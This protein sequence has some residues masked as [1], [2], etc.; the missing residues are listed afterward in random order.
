MLGL[1]PADRL[2]ASRASTLAKADL[3]SNLVVEMT[4]LQGTMGGHYALRGG[5]PMSV[6]TAIAE[7]YDAISSTP[8][9]MAVAI[10]DRLDSLAALFAAGLGPKSSND[11]FGLRR[12]ALHIIENLTANERHFDLPAGLDAAGAPLPVAWSDKARDE[13]MGFIAGR[14][15]VVLREAGHPTSVVK[16]V[17]AEQA[18]DPYAARQAATALAEATKAADWPSLLNAYARCV[19]I[20]RPLKEGYTLHPDALKVA[21]ERA[22]LETLLE[23]EA[24]KDGTVETFVESL[25]RMQPSI[26]EL[27][28]EVLI[29]DDDPAVRGNRLALLQRVSGLA[30]GVADLSMLE[31]F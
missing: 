11:P 16:A 31:G 26:S 4:S 27:F 30:S 6:A 8:P 21:E 17:L 14:L 25:R 12:A 2:V 1:D 10:A 7:Q 23:A 9:A 20:T 5:E 28:E 19:R 13:V 29:M 24:D 15:D 3:A 22:V 18:H